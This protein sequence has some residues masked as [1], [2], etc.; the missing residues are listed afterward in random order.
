MNGNIQEL[1]RRQLRRTCDTCIVR[2]RSL[3]AELSGQEL[4]SLHQIGR[5]RRLKAGERINWDQEPAS[6]LAIVVSGSVKLTKILP[7]GRQQIVG[8]LFPSDFVGQAFS[9]TATCCIEAATDVQLCSFP[10]AQFEALMQRFPS[11]ER[12]MLRIALDELDAARDWMLLLGRKTAREKVASLLLLIAVRQAGRHGD[13]DGQR[14]SLP[15]NREEAGDF[16]GLR[17]ETI[18]RQINRLSSQGII[19]RDGTR[20]I[21]VLDRARLKAATTTPGD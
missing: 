9:A 14:I 6:Q 11:I 19:R 12:R 7:D 13:G 21:T 1:S 5:V 3:C 15:L 8:L 4:C 10:S 18:S 2:D 20:T 17:S 16:L